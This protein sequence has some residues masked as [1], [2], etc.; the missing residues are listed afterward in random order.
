MKHKK[1]GKCSQQVFIQ[2][3]Y[4]IMLLKKR[5]SLVDLSVCF[6]STPIF[7]TGESYKE[8]RKEFMDIFQ[9]KG[10]FLF[11]ASNFADVKKNWGITFSMWRSE[12][13]QASKENFTFDIIDYQNGNIEKIGEKIFYNTD[14]NIGCS[15][16][17]REEVKNIKTYDAPQMTNA[18]N[19]QDKGTGKLAEHALGYYV[20]SANSINENNTYILITSSASNKGHGVSIIENNFMKI[21]SLYSARKLISGKYSNWINI[22]DEYFK[23][24]TNNPE[25]E[26]WNNDAIIYSIFSNSSQQSS[27]RNV[28]YK[29][30]YYNIKNEFFFE[31]KEIIM[32][33][34]EENYNNESYNN[35]IT[36]E[37]ERYVFRILKD[38]KLSKEAKDVLDYS[39]EIL[40]NSFKYRKEFNKFEPQY[41]INNWDAGWYQIKALLK[42]YNS[43]NLKEFNII[44]KALENKMRPMVYKLGFLK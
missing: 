28:K 26:E 36:D 23:P 35:A 8:F 3:I 32:D 25:Y 40:K 18:I 15:S 44:F 10:G 12:K 6:F 2:F 5:Y 30:D 31:S 37:N 39:K 20:N 4:K 34:A 9:F 29:N 24:N 1:V 11:K 14:F 16:W 21:V 41:Q 19:I 43:K 33:Y 17:I 38:A 42:A 27:L 13:G 22:R 7:L